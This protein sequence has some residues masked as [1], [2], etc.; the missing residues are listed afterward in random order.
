MRIIVYD[1][2]HS[3][4]AAYQNEAGGVYD[5]MVKAVD[6]NSPV[7]LDFIHIKTVSF[8]FLNAS[9]GKLFLNY[10]LFQVGAL[11]STC[12]TDGIEDYNDKLYTVLEKIREDKICEDKDKIKTP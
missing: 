1:I 5:A 4:Y 3:D 8:I 12:N 6:K 2:L 9:I 10:P 7:I 11:L